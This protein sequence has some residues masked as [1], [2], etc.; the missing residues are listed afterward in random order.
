[1]GP[2]S[3]KVI[4]RRAVTTTPEIF[5]ENELIIKWLVGTKQISKK[6]EKLRPI[7]QA[8]VSNCVLATA[9]RVLVSQD[10]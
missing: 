9:E 1:V 10:R 5:A 3:A 6:N 8:V 4:N 7:F 2:D